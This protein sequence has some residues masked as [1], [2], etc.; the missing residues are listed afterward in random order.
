MIYYNK[1]IDF[2]KKHNLLEKES[3]IFISNHTKNIN[4]ENY[5][6]REFIGCYYEINEKGKLISFKVCVPEITNERTLLINIHEYIHAL[7][8]YNMLNKKC[9]IGLEKEVL[10]MLYEKLY[11]LENEEVSMKEYQHQLLETI[12]EIGTPEYIIGNEVSDK[13]IMHTDEEI[14]K[15]NKKA[16]SMVRKLKK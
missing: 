5:E 13:L 1:F 16:K 4:Y 11:I 7:L 3:F 9:D 10:P 8:L 12:N 2:L 15:L 6:E 14:M